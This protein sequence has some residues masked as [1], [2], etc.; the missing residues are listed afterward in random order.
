MAITWTI[1]GLVVVC[2]QDIFCSLLNRFYQTDR[3]F[4]SMFKFLL[5]NTIRSFFYKVLIIKIEYDKLRFMK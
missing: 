4:N 2:I 1:S 5:E 3:T